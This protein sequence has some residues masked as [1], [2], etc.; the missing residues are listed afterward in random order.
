[1]INI[2]ELPFYG[3]KAEF[4]GLVDRH[5]V[6]VVAVPTGGGKSTSFPLFL[7]EAGYGN[8]GMIGVTQPR[9]ASQR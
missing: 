9:I 6:V 1:M 3:H 5:Q 7:L 2:T 8:R 4:L